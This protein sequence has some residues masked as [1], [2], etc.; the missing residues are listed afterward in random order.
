MCTQVGRTLVVIKRYQNL[1]LSRTS[2]Q[3]GKRINLLACFIQFCQFLLV[4]H[5]YFIVPGETIG[6]FLKIMQITVIEF[7]YTEIGPNIRRTSKSVL[8]LIQTT[9]RQRGLWKLLYISQSLF[10]PGF[11]VF[12]VVLCVEKIISA[13]K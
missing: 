12:Q 1:I 11:A 2:S 10:D 3:I 9:V 6:V 13:A 8:C 4:L 7:K 5:T